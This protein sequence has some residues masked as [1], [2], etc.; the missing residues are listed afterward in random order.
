VDRTTAFIVI[1]ILLLL[2]MVVVFLMQR[3]GV[4]TEG[5]ARRHNELELNRRRVALVDAAYEDYYQRHPVAQF[6]VAKGGG[7]VLFVTGGGLMYVASPRIWQPDWINTAIIALGFGVQVVATVVCDVMGIK[8]WR[9]L[10]DVV[11]SSERPPK[12]QSD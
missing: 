12:D 6:L 5:F 1:E 2:S 10:I 3:P 8:E 4:T 9:H 11:R 7:F